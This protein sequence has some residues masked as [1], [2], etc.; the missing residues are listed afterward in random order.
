MTLVVP[1]QGEK[2]FLDLV[3]AVGYTLKLF[4]NNVTVTESLVETDFTEATFTGYSAKALTGG[5][6]T[7]AT[8]DPS[9]GAYALQSFTSSADQAPQDIYGYYVVLTADSKL[10]WFE[11]FGSA[12]TV[13]NDGDSIRITPRVT[14]ADTQD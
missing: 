6:W 7:T 8:G 1:N 3:L 2:A 4:K 12:V 9:T 14:L 13:Q 10:R 5:S 11:K